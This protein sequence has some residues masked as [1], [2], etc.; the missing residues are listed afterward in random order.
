MSYEQITFMGS[1]QTYLLFFPCSGKSFIDFY[2]V[3]LVAFG[4]SMCLV[5]LLLRLITSGPC[6]GGGDGGDGSDGVARGRGRSFSMRLLVWQLQPEAAEGSRGAG[7]EDGRP[8]KLAVKSR[9]RRPFTWAA[10]L[11]FL[12]YYELRWRRWRRWGGEAQLLRAAS[13]LPFVCHSHHV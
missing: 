12:L 10:G 3:S 8:T 11:V 7:E 5:T 13:L 1:R 4:T 6:E 9:R 2:K